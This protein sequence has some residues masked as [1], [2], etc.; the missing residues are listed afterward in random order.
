M[1][2]KLPS[3]KKPRADPHSGT[4]NQEWMAFYMK[5]TLL[6]FLSGQD[7]SVLPQQ[8]LCSIRQRAGGRDE[9]EG[10]CSLEDVLSLIEK[11][12]SFKKTRL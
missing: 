8:D 4:L 7:I 2:W 5:L 10:F 3:G 11:E 1:G 6:A 9:T 12:S